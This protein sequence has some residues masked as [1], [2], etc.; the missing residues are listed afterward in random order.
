MKLFYL[1]TLSCLV[2]LEC[3]SCRKDIKFVSDIEKEMR[4]L[5]EAVNK[6]SIHVLYMDSKNLFRLGG[7]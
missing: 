1:C 7:I 2:N 6:V 3:C 4:M 5:V